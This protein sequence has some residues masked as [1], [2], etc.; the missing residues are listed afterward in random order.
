VCWTKTAATTGSSRKPAEAPPVRN[1]EYRLMASAL[2]TAIA[3]AFGVL[4]S[5]TNP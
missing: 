1:A 4:A 2:F 3:T 5:A